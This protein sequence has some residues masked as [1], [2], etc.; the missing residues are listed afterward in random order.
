MATYV[1]NINERT[2]TGK[3]LLGYLRNLG[4]IVD[5]YT[6]RPNMETLKAIDELRS[7]KVI[8][9]KNFEDYKRKMQ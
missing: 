7:G 3:S 4:V 9:C 5:N 1:V 8:R 2:N 6:K